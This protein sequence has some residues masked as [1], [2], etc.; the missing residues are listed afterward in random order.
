MLVIAATEPCSL[1]DSDPPRTIE[2]QSPLGT[3]LRT[4]PLRPMPKS[5][6]GLP[7]PVIILPGR[8]CKTP[9]SLGK[10][11]ASNLSAQTTTVRSPSDI[12]KEERDEVQQKTE[13]PAM[14][15]TSTS[16]K[17]LQKLPISQATPAVS[18]SSTVFTAAPLLTPDTDQP[19][20]Q[21]ESGQSEQA[22]QY[23]S[24]GMKC[25]VDF[26]KIYQFTSNL[27]LKKHTQPLT[28]MG[29]YSYFFNNYICCSLLMTLW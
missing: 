26:E 18:A 7:P 22:W 15:S 5:G 4:I 23:R 25:V 6:P 3:G 16:S 13:D 21:P 29:M 11:T 12:A 24:V 10:D 14:P 19:D 2:S 1:R 20:K 27:V 9:Q 28:P 8:T 17:S